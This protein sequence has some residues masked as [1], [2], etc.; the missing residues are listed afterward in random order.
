MSLNIKATRLKAELS[1]DESFYWFYVSIHLEEAGDLPPFLKDIALVEYHL[2]DE[3]I[4]N[5]DVRA[6]N[7]SKGFAYRVWLYGFIKASA[8]VITKGGEKVTIPPTR[9]EW[10]VTDAEVALNGKDELSWRVAL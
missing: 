1:D 4:E 3:T 6:T 2:L 5:G 7:P 10:A 9:L 8:D